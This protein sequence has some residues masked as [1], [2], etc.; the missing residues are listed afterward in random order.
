VK[1]KHEEGM[2]GT[3]RGRKRNRIMR[4]DRRKKED[5]MKEEEGK[6]KE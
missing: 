2:E 3:N 1:E 4:R 5:E 6:I